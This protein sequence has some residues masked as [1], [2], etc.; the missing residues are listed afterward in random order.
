[1][2]TKVN[3]SFF[4]IFLALFFQPVAFA[5]EKDVILVST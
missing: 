1:M 3:I 5:S 4:S 2:N